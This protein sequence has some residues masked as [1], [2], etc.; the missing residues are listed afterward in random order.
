MHTS[1]IMYMHISADSY[2]ISIQYHL[3][4]ITSVIDKSNKLPSC[5]A[6]VD[7]TKVFE[8]SIFELYRYILL[9]I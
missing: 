1:P 7:D 4:I 3:L 9:L 2:M 5:N 8:N 6:S